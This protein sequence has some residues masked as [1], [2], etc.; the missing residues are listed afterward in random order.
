MRKLIPLL[1]IPILIPSLSFAAIQFSTTTQ[2]NA[3]GASLT[4]SHT[5]SGS[6][7]LLIVESYVDAAEGTTASVTYNGTALTKISEQHTAATNNDIS[8]W[9]LLNA[10]SGTH[11]VV[12]TP[13]AS[14]QVYSWANSYT[15][16]KQTG[17]PDSYVT[18]NYTSGT[19]QNE[20]LTTTI[21][22]QDSWAMMVA[23][24]SGAASTLSAGTGSTQRGTTVNDNQSGI[25]DSNGPLSTGSRS[26]TIN[27]TS[28]STTFGAI[29]VSFSPDPTTT[30][31]PATTSTLIM[32]TS[33][34]Q[35]IGDV[36]NTILFL[37]QGGVVVL[38]AYIVYKLVH[39]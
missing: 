8:L 38:A 21:V 16:V 19:R 31:T 35:A 33:T 29:M 32:S 1:F 37:I 7:T 25:Y 5:I 28:G 10:S 11:N 3:N 20:T 23:R 36:F 17:Q 6:S 12:V 39:G 24:V 13:S 2:A 22:A 26:M 18:D 14:N 34:D 15:G 30:S 9:Y 27:G 4:Y